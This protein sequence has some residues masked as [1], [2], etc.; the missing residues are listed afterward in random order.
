MS[1]FAI[2][3]PNVLFMSIARPLFGLGIFVTL[4]LVFKPFAQVLLRAALQLFKPRQP[5]E[6]GASRN[7]LRGVL[8]LN[9]MA[10]E[11]ETSQPNLSAELRLLASRG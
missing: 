8:M 3:L 1:A 2:G 4:A 11:L 9:R 7:N 5:R 6:L 10:R